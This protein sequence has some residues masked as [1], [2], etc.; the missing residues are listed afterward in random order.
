MTGNAPTGGP[1]TGGLPIRRILWISFLLAVFVYG[2]VGYLLFAPAASPAPLLPNWIWAL[3]AA[4]LAGAAVWLPGNVPMGR[5]ETPSGIRTPELVGWSL[6]E[7]VAVVGLVSVALGGNR[8]F[9][10]AYL[11]VAAAILWLQRPGD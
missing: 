7:S 8:I 3:I 1:E 11:V 2:V 10:L 5:T 6:A 4:V 9:L